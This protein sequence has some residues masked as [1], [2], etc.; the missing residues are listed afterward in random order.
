MVKNNHKWNA[1]QNIT[2]LYA[3]HIHQKWW[4]RRNA[5]DGWVT[6][7]WNS[8]VNSPYKRQSMIPVSIKGRASFQY[9]LKLSSR[10]LSRNIFSNCLLLCEIVS[11]SVLFCMQLNCQ[12]YFVCLRLNRSWIFSFTQVFWYYFETCLISLSSCLN[13][14]TRRKALSFPKCFR[15]LLSIFGVY[16]E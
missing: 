1:R 6:F 11:V 16:N 9:P 15:T 4:T 7:V 13:N 14:F 10:N 5:M 12:Q 2:H 8:L 3:I